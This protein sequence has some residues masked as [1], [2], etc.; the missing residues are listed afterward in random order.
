MN[1]QPTKNTKQSPIVK[2][3]AIGKSKAVDFIG[4]WLYRFIRLFKKSNPEPNQSFLYLVKKLNYPLLKHYW[5]KQGV[6]CV[7]MECNG[8][9][10]IAGFQQGYIILRLNNGKFAVDKA[11][12]GQAITPKY[13]QEVKGV[14]NSMSV[15]LKDKISKSA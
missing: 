8:Y 3:S 6:E 14:I 4:Y 7:N 5:N 9:K 12:R 1:Y 2:E 10:L 11:I 15:T 13:I